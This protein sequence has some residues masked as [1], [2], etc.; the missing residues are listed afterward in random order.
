MILRIGQVQIWNYKSIERAVV[1]L[2]PL[3]FLVG[4]NGAG[5]S[6]FIDALDFVRQCLTDSVEKA[7]KDRGGIDAVR[8]RCAEDARS[9][10]IRLILEEES[11]GFIDYAFELSVQK[12]GQFKVHRE[13]C[14][15]PNWQAGGLQYEIIDGAYETR[16]PDSLGIWPTPSVD[17]L[18]LPSF[19]DGPFFWPIYRDLRSI[20]RHSI[21]PN[22]I[23]K[24]QDP[25]CGYFLKPDGSNAAAVLEELMNGNRDL[26]E[27]LCRLLSVV[28]PGVKKV[29]W[30]V[31][32]LEGK[33][34]CGL[35]FEVDVGLDEPATFD[36]LSI[37]DGTLRVL[38]LLLAAYQTF[39]NEPERPLLVA[40]E[41]PEMAVHPATAEL[42]V[43]VLLDAARQNRILVT[44]HSPDILDYKELSD[45]QFRVVVMKNGRT[46]IAPVSPATHQAIKE[47]LYTPGEL[48]SVNE[49][50]PDLEAAER[51]ARQLDLFGS[52][53]LTES[54]TT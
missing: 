27:R 30:A 4:P 14:R 31:M 32:E 45:T 2:E 12:N 37:S 47:C 40:I 53:M 16:P 5:K 42:V 24:W 34:K 10:G 41:E 39:L 51:K 15:Y 50:N 36:A 22:E 19:P 7:V 28:A 52:R 9:L 13:R 8:C 46:V 20:Y 48:L 25:A 54:Q 1:D 29:E 35:Q 17:G 11:A 18:T 26:Y 38:W 21:F 23:R 43:Q 49:L 33:Q 3:T 44:T 6:N